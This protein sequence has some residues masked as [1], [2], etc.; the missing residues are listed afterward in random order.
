MGKTFDN[1][2]AET[3]NKAK[4]DIKSRG[5]SVRSQQTFSDAC[6]FDPN[7]NQYLNKALPQCYIQ[8]EK[9]KR[10]Q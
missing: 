4:V 2:R 7:V 3:S 5:F 10:R 6:V 8:N 9:K 1:R